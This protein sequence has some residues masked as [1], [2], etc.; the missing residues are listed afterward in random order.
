MTT[1]PPSPAD[2]PF[3]P[4]PGGW[5]LVP[6]D[7]GEGTT[8][9][10]RVPKDPDLLLDD[11]GVLER[12]RFN[13][14]MPYWAWIWDSAPAMARLLVRRPWASGARVLELGAGLGL[15]GLALAK[16]R[17]CRVLLTDHDPLALQAARAQVRAS[18]LAGVD[19]AS[20]DW[21]DPATGPVGPFDGVLGCDVT[22]EAG[23]HGPVL[24]TI[25]RLLA[26]DG[27]AFVAD[28][29]RTRL[30]GFAARAVARGFRVT[31]V[32]GRGEPAEAVPGAFRLLELR[33]A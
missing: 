17:G 2:A 28:P 8:L 27:A 4:L 24:D 19:V 26:P 7:L 9:E 11:A 12:N 6:Y 22:Y 21:N 31:V 20:F 23:F 14:A 16:A 3:P 5:E 32:D 15:V 29:G 10:L 13:D 25:E 18:G 33:R 1:A 30:P